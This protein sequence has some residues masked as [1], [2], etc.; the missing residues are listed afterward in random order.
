ML[1]QSALIAVLTIVGPVAS[2][3]GQ[4][5]PNTG[6]DLR[7]VRFSGDDRI[8][9]AA[10]RGRVSLSPPETRVRLF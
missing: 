5:A 3:R 2:G 9:V 1:K 10:L 7:R 6:N 8:G 4:L